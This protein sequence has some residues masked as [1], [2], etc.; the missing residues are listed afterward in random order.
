MHLYVKEKKN[1]RFKTKFFIFM[2][3]IRVMFLPSI[4][5]SF[6]LNPYKENGSYN[7]ASFIQGYSNVYDDFKHLDGISHFF[8][9]I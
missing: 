6:L 9:N 2:R 3:E 4:E 7:E 8:Q 1:S 5:H